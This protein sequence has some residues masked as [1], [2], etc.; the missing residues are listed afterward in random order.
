LIIKE[1]A[2]TMK[3]AAVLIKSEVAMKGEVTANSV[4]HPECRTA[5]I[6]REP[7][8]ETATMEPTA[9]TGRLRRAG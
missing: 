5:G 9:M 4:P 3:E 1:T 8:M 2:V 7:T 6:P